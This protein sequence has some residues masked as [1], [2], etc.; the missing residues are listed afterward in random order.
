MKMNHVFSKNLGAD[1]YC[2]SDGVWSHDVITVC[3]CVCQRCGVEAS[4]CDLCVGGGSKVIF[5]VHKAND[6]E[7]LVYIL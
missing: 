4:F 3:V 2:S 7:K 6:G 1:G 5:I